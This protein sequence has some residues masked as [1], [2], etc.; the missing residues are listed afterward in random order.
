MCKPIDMN[1]LRRTIEE[2]RAAIVTPSWLQQVERQLLEGGAALAE[3]AAHRGATGGHVFSNR[4]YV[5]GD[6]SRESFVRSP[7]KREATA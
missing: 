7:G 4:I 6:G 1:D 5:V 2:G 3:L